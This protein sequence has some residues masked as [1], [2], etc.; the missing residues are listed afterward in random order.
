MRVIIIVISWTNI[1]LNSLYWNINKMIKLNQDNGHFTYIVHWINIH[2]TALRLSFNLK[3][4]FRNYRNRQQDFKNSKLRFSRL[5]TFCLYCSSSFL[6]ASS[7]ATQILRYKSCWSFDRQ[8]R[9]ASTNASGARISSIPVCAKY[10]FIETASDV[11]IML[12]ITEWKVCHVI[13]PFL[14]TSIASYTC[15]STSISNS[16]TADHITII[17]YKNRSIC[18]PFSM[19]L[20]DSKS[21]KAPP[22]PWTLARRKKRLR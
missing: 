11:P 8:F 13:F 19:L 20:M 16:C 3:K 15:I 17:S 21:F 12:S 7:R 2:H 22:E 10:S 18:I 5:S 6:S 1:L 14:L 9:V 4:H